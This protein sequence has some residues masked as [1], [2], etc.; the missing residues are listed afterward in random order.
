M[1]TGMKWFF[2]ILAGLVLVSILVG[3]GVIALN[4]WHDSGWMMGDNHIRIVNGE[5]LR[6]WQAAPGQ[7]MPWNNM[8]G[9]DGTGR[10]VGGIQT[11]RF[12]FFTPLRMLFFCAFAIG[13]LMLIAL[14]M[15]YLVRGSRRPSESTITSASAV[16]LTP[17]TSAPSPTHTTAQ[18][19]PHCGQ[20][21]QEG[22][23]HCPYC[24]G[25][26]PEQA[27]NIPPTG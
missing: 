8:H 6:S 26:L 2:G 11:S 7:K 13:F 10:F 5:R 9:Y 14:G 16:S 25:Q 18:A 17:T 27:E 4:R 12:G 24:G 19:C 23:K 1:K 20:L 3:V 15:I 21:V 22:W